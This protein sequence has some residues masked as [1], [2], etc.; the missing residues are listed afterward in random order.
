MSSRVC[1]DPCLQARGSDATYYDQAGYC[2]PGEYYDREGYYDQALMD[3]KLHTIVDFLTHETKA[4]SPS[5]KSTH[6]GL[7]APATLS[8][9]EPHTLQE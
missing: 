4:T 6:P 8:C 3:G 1:A 5:L 7:A 2:D 9:P